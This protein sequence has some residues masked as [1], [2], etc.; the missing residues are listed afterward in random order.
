MLTSAGLEISEYHR[1]M[2]FTPANLT[3]PSERYNYICVL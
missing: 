2:P 3:M 1:Q